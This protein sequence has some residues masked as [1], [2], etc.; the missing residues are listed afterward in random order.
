MKVRATQTSATWIFPDPGELDKAVILRQR[1]DQPASDYG[2]AEEY[3]NIK[4]VWAKIRQVG[5]T[6]LHESTQTDNKITHYFTVFFRPGITSDFEILHAGIVYAVRRAM[7]LNNA[8]LFLRLECEEL[9][10]ESVSDEMYG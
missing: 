1:V 6:T 5:A 8:G 7:D 3:I 4:T 10:A 9:G 2:T